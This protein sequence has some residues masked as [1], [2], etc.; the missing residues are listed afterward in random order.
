M[1][2]RLV[3]KGG[4]ALPPKGLK[5]VSESKELQRLIAA[6][7]KAE[8]DIINEIAR[9]RAGGLVDYHAEAALERVQ[10][11]LHRLEQNGASG[12]AVP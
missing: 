1:P 8:T 3:N 9:L 11:I 4:N 12:W 5:R 10:T 7:L 6:F 2:P